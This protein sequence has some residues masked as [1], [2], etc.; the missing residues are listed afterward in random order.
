MKHPRVCKECR[1]WVI[2]AEDDGYCRR[3]DPGVQTGELP[4]D[5]EKEPPD[6]GDL[7]EN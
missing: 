6:N 7:Q 5:G 3:P 4:P 2:L 1:F